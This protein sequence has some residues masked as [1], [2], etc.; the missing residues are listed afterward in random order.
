MAKFG[1]PE[2]FKKDH[3]LRH[4][5]LVY[6]NERFNEIST[7][8]KQ[9]VQNRITKNTNMFIKGYGN[10]PALISCFKELLFNSREL[11]DSLLIYINKATNG[12]TNKHFLKFSKALMSGKYD[13]FE[14]SILNFLKEN[15]TY[16][17]HIRKFRNEA[18]NKI[19]NFEFILITN[20]IIAKLKILIQQNE[21]ELI[22]YLEISDQEKA[23]KE[24]SYGCQITLDEYFPEIVNFWKIIFDIME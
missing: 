23:I 13:K 1:I 7:S 20:N 2:D 18:K 22:P 15:F 17:F 12:N 4:E 5:Q 24:M 14:L 9:A 11:L 3:I 8:K 16:V 6:A 19:S 10:D 21:L